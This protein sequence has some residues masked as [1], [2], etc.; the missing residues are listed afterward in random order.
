MTLQNWIGNAK[1]EAERIKKEMDEKSNYVKLEEGDNEVVITLE[2]APKNFEDRY[3][4]NKYR[5]FTLTE[6]KWEI[7]EFLYSQLVPKLG[8]LDD[9]CKQ[10]KVVVNKTGENKDTRYKLV[11]VVAVKDGGQ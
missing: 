5:F 9:S 8:E 11:S 10:A 1:T 4:N 6:K 2:D 3:G 7:T